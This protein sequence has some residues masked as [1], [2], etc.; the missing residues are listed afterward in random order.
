MARKFKVSISLEEE[1][2]SVAECSRLY[3]EDDGDAGLPW[4][5]GIALSEAIHGIASFWTGDMDDLV[6]G[7]VAGLQEDG[8]CE[9]RLERE[10]VES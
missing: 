9:V 7:F 1:G 4:C 8:H 2:G 10:H 5:A 6:R 3:V